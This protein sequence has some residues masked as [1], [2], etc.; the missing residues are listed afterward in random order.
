MFYSKEGAVCSAVI[1]SM[2][3]ALKAQ[4]LLSGHALRSNVKK[5]SPASRTRGCIYGIEFDCAQFQ[6]VRSLLESSN[7]EVLE[8]LR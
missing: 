7:T 8:Y 6:N 1:G 5:I 4:R 2:T 3:A